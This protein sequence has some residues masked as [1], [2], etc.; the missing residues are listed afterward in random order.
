[1]PQVHLCLEPLHF[2]FF[3]PLFYVEHLIILC[4]HHYSFQRL[5]HW[6]PQLPKSHMEL[7]AIYVVMAYHGIAHDRVVWMNLFSLLNQLMDE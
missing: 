3:V 1:M 4:G 6:L 5:V 2:A 7:L